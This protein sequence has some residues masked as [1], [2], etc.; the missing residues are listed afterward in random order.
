MDVMA[1]AELK[2]RFAS[3]REA[4]VMWGAV[5]ADDPTSLDGQVEDDILH[6]IV[7][8]ATAPSVRVSLDDLLAC[9]QAARGGSI[10]SDDEGV[11]ED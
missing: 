1:R 5:S 9:L 7:P 10:I 8:R 3:R 6:V 4:Q 2:L 11:E